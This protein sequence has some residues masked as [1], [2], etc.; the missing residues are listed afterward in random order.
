MISVEVEQ[1]GGWMDG[2]MEAW[3]LDWW[4]WEDLLLVDVT[5]PHRDERLLQTQDKEIQRLK[6]IFK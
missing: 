2:W 3:L 4:N 5:L 6:S 1:Q